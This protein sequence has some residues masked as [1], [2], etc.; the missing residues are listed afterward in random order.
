MFVFVFGFGAL[1]RGPKVEASPTRCRMVRC[2]EVPCP[3]PSKVAVPQRSFTRSPGCDLL[4]F[5]FWLGGFPYQ[6]RLQNTGRPYSNLV[7]M[8]VQCLLEMTTLEAKEDE[9]YVDTDRRTFH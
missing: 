2:Q 8:D 7:Q 1:K 4:P 5:L 9:P 6:N 3:E